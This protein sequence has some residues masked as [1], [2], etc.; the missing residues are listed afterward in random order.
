VGS[1]V[2]IGIDFQFSL[3]SGASNNRNTVVVG[4]SDTNLAGF[5]LNA[6]LQ[7]LTTN[8]WRLKSSA[9]GSQAVVTSANM[10]VA[11]ETSGTS[12]W[13][14]IETTLTKLAAADSFS[15]TIAL[16]DLGATGLSTPSIIQSVAAA[17]HT[18]A[19]LYG[20]SDW[21]G[22]VLADRPDDIGM[23]ALTYDNFAVVPEPSTA[24]LALGLA[25]FSFLFIRRR[26]RS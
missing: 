19:D 8:S 6:Q 5:R 9:G 12:N 25:C 13:I 11:S 24:A 14:R 3:D 10:G 1:S 2:T 17:T 21:Y 22:F 18:D 4:F 16:Y 23:S 20:A 15:Q 26:S 7:R